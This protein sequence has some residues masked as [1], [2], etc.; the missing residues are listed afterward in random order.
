MDTTH[1]DHAPAS[2]DP[3][4]D[5]QA[6]GA[7]ASGAPVASQAAGA[8]RVLGTPLLEV[9]GLTKHYGETPAVD[10]FELV[11]HAGDIL[12]L[13]GPNGAGKTTTLRTLAGVMPIESGSVRI[14]GHD[15][16][17]AELDAKRCLAWVPDQPQPFDALTVWEHL[18]F[19]AALY[20]VADWKK[21]ATELLQHFELF[22]KRDALGGELS[23]GMCQKLAL[24]MALLHEPKVLLLD[25]PLS[26]L[27]PVGI[28]AAKRAIAGRARAG[29]AVVLSSHQLTVVEQ[30]STRL[31]IVRQGRVLF[32]GGLDEA[33]ERAH[34]GAGSDLEEVFFAVTDGAD[35]ADARATRD[36]T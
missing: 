29:G 1:D 2:A 30:L 25:E 18:D 31:M 19:T 16:V 12:G 35:G 10:G 22:G 11:L 21:R 23:R 32:D 6:T 26:G 15:L 27:D 7:Q 14:G 33:R 5:S 17:K 34:A 13:V 28:R 9:H 20:R 3:A 4:S 24:C 8:A 36:E